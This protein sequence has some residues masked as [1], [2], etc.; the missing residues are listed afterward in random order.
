[1][2]VKKAEVLRWIIFLTSDGIQ[3]TVADSIKSRGVIPDLT[4]FLEKQVNPVAKKAFF[5]HSLSQKS[6]S[7]S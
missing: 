4:L 7:L 6:G 1:M 3:M 2:L 5:Q